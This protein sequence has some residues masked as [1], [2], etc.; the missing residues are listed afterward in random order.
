MTEK[1]KADIKLDIEFVGAFDNCHMGCDS[2]DFITNTHTFYKDG[3]ATGLS[4]K[5]E[6]QNHELCEH[7][8]EHL[9]GL[10]REKVTKQI[11]GDI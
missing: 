11:S 1:L 9:E 3:K 10:L 6:C 4:L 2:C 7:L 5:V 8:T